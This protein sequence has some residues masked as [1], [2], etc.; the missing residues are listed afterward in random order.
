MNIK[1][2][3]L[4][5]LKKGSG[6]FV[7][8]CHRQVPDNYKY[9]YRDTYVCKINQVRFFL[10]DYFF[11]RKYKTIEYRGEFA[12]EIQFALPFAY[13]HY[14]NGTLKKT[15]SFPATKE[16]YF[17][18]EDHEELF[19][20][21]TNEG[22]YNF[23]LPRIVYSQDYN[24]KKWLPV[25]LK[26]YYVNNVYVYK[27]PILIIANKYNSEWDD[28]PVNF[29]N[30]EVLDE[31]IT[32]LKKKYTIIY[33]RPQPKHIVNDNSTIY[34][35][36]EFDWLKKN[37]PDVIL[38]QDLYR[39]NKIDARNF[40]HFQLC[41]YAN[42]NHFISVHGGTATLASYFGGKNLILSKIGPEHYFN[43]FKKLYPKFSN[44]EIIH[45]K[46]DE[47][48]ILQCKNNF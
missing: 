32:Y 6:L 22:N 35:L 36:Q 16:L 39:E 26:Q 7:K 47:E 8:I 23:E 46:T 5:T 33:N 15:R 12:A 48:L 31:M 38:M 25:P 27:K 2:I 30:I 13:W 41:V 45:A 40:N 20:E 34:D 43:C 11:K 42:C 9:F 44:A 24:L 17:F 29:M 37:H 3:Y 21:R 19:S 18:S 14:K 10:K 28:A 4:T 1:D